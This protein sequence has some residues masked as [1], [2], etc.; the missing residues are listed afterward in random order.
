MTRISEY[1]YGPIALFMLLLQ[2][3]A[4]A[5][6]APQ[7][8]T[9][10]RPLHVVK[11]EFDGPSRFDRGLLWKISRPGSAPSYLFGT[12]HLG[13]DDVTSLPDAVSASLK[14]SRVFVM[15][16]LPDMEQSTKL[17]QM[18]FFDDHRRLNDFLS[19]TMYDR[20]VSILAA[21]HLTEESASLLKP[22]AAFL[23]M[24]YP[25]DLRKI[26][27]LQLLETA[28][29]NG[30]EVNGLETLQEQGEIFN[31]MKI[32]DQIRLLTDA[33]CHYDR[34]QKDFEVMKSLYLKR[35]LKALYLYSQRYSFDDNSVYESLT[36]K[37]LTDRNHVMADRMQPILEKGNAFIAIGAMHLPGKEGVLALLHGKKYR[38]SRVY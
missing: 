17:S 36:R 12:I 8:P 10:C 37:I 16:A 14:E 20:V 19:A 26:L 13:D 34:F 11:G 35:D 5:Q 7:P 22:W 3:A 30:L 4:Y 32:Q 27:D 31:R 18:M 28:T 6:P 15:E 1:L 9:E 21:Y 2:G 23:T 38:I 33:A 25:A 29:E 24:S